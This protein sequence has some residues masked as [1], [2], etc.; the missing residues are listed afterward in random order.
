MI[1]YKLSGFTRFNNFTKNYIKKAVPDLNKE[2]FVIATHFNKYV[3]RSMRNTPKDFSRSYG[4]EGH[5]PSKP[6][7]PPAVGSGNLINR[8]QVRKLNDGA[9]WYI[10]GAKYAPLLEE[11]VLKSWVVRVKKKR[12]LSDGMTFFGKESI[13]PPLKPRPF[14]K[15]ALKKNRRLYE[16]K[17]KQ[18]ILKTIRSSNI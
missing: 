8:M 14:A 5:H 2:L 16:S 3:K 17:L 11:G 4:I 18:R 10:D 7:H 15:P 13:H 1:E 12:V 6:G 9:I